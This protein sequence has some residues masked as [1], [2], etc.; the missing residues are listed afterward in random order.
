MVIDNYNEIKKKFEQFAIS[1]K[2]KST[3]QFNQIFD[4]N[5]IC[6]ISI[7]KDYTDGDQHSLFGIKNFVENMPDCDHFNEKVYN[8]VCKIGNHEAQQ[9]SEIV[10]VAFRVDQDVVKSFEFT[11]LVVSHWIKKEGWLI[12]EL[13]MEIEKN[14]GNFEEFANQ[15]YF[16]DTHKKWSPGF[17]LPCISGELDSP[18]RK[19]KE[20]INTQLNTEDQIRETFAKYA[21]AIDFLSFDHMNDVTSDKLVCLMAPWGAMTKR[22]WM[23]YLKNYR[24]ADRL[25]VHPAKLGKATISGNTAHVTFYR[26][27]GHNQRTYPYIWTKKNWD[28]EHACARYD[29][30]LIRVNEK[31]KISQC[32]YYLGIIELGDYSTDLFN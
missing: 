14:N 18:W 29:M 12:D 20:P 8:Y 11:I 16:E 23:G 6:Y 19:I 7:V 27:A 28:I 26:M 21:F 32:K 13:R 25:W 3:K 9:F 10:C 5:L 24:Q 2:T 4:K 17:H 15:W 1:L 31:W 30:Q 22:K